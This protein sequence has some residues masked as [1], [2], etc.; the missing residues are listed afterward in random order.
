[1]EC[2]EKIVRS[3]QCGIC[4][5]ELVESAGPGYTCHDER[6]TSSGTGQQPDAGT[7]M[8]PKEKR[9]CTSGGIF[10]SNGMLNPRYCTVPEDK[11][12]CVLLPADEQVIHNGWAIRYVCCPWEWNYST[13]PVPH[14]NKGGMS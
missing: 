9:N 4:S 7:T 14:C 11:H 5:D 3:N 6:V 8:P 13:Q 1:M 2:T 12:N 10:G